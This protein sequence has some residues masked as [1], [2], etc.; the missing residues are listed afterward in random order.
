MSPTLS[1]RTSLEFAFAAAKKGTSGPLTGHN[2]VFVVTIENADPAAMDRTRSMVEARV[3][4]ELDHSI[5]DD[6]LARTD[7]HAV[8]RWIWDHLD[9]GVEGL[10]EVRLQ[11]RPGEWVALRNE[12]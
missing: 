11:E 6:R 8:A 3:V 4:Q 5:L 12:E 1:V 9:G 10:A 7:L 2:Y